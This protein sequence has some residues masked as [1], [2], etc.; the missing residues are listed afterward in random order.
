MKS[1]ISY[2]RKN[3]ISSHDWMDNTS[4]KNAV[5]TSMEINVLETVAKCR[6]QEKQTARSQRARQCDTTRVILMRERIIMTF[7]SAGRVGVISVGRYYG[8][9]RYYAQNYAPHSVVWLRLTLENQPKARTTVFLLYAF[10]VW[11]HH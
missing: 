5:K 2:E 10:V 1:S 8:L 9:L 6:Q 4:K 7:A 11:K 3:G